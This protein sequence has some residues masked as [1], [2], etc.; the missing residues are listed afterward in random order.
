M[1][2]L[3]IGCF[4]NHQIAAAVI[5]SWGAAEALAFL[6]SW[7]EAGLQQRHLPAHLESSWVRPLPAGVE[8]LWGTVAGCWGSP[9][10]G[11]AE[12]W[13]GSPKPA[14]WG[15]LDAQ[16]L[17]MALCRGPLPCPQGARVWIPDSVEV[18]REAEITRGYKEGDTVLHLRLENGS[19]RL[20]PCSP[21]GPSCAGHGV[22]RP[23]VGDSDSLH[24]QT[25]LGSSAGRGE[26]HAQ[27]GCVPSGV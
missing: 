3:G 18:W 7:G 17:A 20:E 1:S 25:S 10:C 12:R 11:S 27:P 2:V 15:G 23:Q 24:P 26:A 8:G 9:R 5:T 4:Q 19:V 21:A 22:G 6:W 16:R 13:P 14:P